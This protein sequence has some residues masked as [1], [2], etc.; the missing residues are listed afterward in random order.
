MNVYI[1]T[2]HD[3][4]GEDTYW[5]QGVWRTAKEAISAAEALI[6]KWPIDNAVWNQYES[7]L[8]EHSW[9][10]MPTH[11]SPLRWRKGALRLSIN[12]HSLTEDVSLVYLTLRD[13]TEG[14]VV[15]GGVYAAAEQAAMNLKPREFIKA[16]HI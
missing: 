11:A 8:Q 16:Y 5:L 7:A 4:G 6:E 14:T 15:I 2:L 3:D 9:S 1:L 12:E 10:F 13:C